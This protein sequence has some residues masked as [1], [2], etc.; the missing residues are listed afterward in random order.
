MSLY[1]LALF[2]P[3]GCISETSF[4]LSDDSNLNDHVDMLVDDYRRAYKYE[5]ALHST[6]YLHP[7]NSFGAT[8]VKREVFQ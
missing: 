1:T 3:T 6:I 4:N 8:I 7:A 2:Q 5:G